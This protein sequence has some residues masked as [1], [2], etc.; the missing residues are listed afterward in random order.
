MATVTQAVSLN[1]DEL[2]KLAPAGAN[3]LIWSGRE[4]HRLI[5]AHT[6]TKTS[7]IVETT[8]SG[9]NHFRTVDTCRRAGYRV[10]MHYVFLSSLK[11]A[12]S[13][14]QLRVKLGGHDVPEADQLRRYEKSI[15]NAARLIPFCDEAFVYNNDTREGHQIVATYRAG[16]LKFKSMHLSWLP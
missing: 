12:N 6:S 4:M 7:F 1:P 16:R 3:P 13:R 8:L 10:A 11:L 15:G 14:V 5:D 9:S 2:A